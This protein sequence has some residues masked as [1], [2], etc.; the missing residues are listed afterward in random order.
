MKHRCFTLI[1]VLVVIGIMAL[2][3]A[4]LFP[5]LQKSRQQAKAV[6]CRSN[7]R[8][9]FI[10]LTMYET[11]NHTL[12]H[13]FD[14]TPMFPPEGDYAGSA[15]FDRRGWWWF[16]HLEDYFS[17]D[18]GKKQVL[19]CPSRQ[20]RNSILSDDILCGNYG[21]N[22]SICKDSNGR[23]SRAEFIGTPLCTGDIPHPAKTL[24]LVDSGYSIINWWHVTDKPPFTL[25]NTIEDAAYIPGLEINRKKRLWPGQ[26]QDALNG[27][28]PN[29]TVNVGFADGHVD[30]LKAEELFV[31]KTDEGYKNQIPLWFPK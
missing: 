17:K 28:H 16:N 1:E 13:A 23:K 2:L 25:G 14:N 26:E 22:Q 29:K 11:E 18:K 21:V 24:L 15:Q 10:G 12:P 6:L 4:V 30:R 19:W 5:T 8:Q 20:V 9:L 7:I 3:M 27:R 31:E